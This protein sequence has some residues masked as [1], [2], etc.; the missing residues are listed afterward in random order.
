MGPERGTEV[1]DR[2]PRG[3]LEADLGPAD[4]ILRHGEES[5]RASASYRDPHRPDRLRIGHAAPSTPNPRACRG[6]PARRESGLAADETVLIA[7]HERI[8]ALAGREVADLEGDAP[9]QDERM[10]ATAIMLRDDEESGP[11]QGGIA[12]ASDELGR[13]PRDVP[14]RQEHEPGNR[15]G[16]ERRRGPARST[17][18]SPPV[19][20][21]G[22]RPRPR[23][24][25][26]HRRS[27]VLRV[28]RRAGRRRPR[29]PRRPGAG[30]SRPDGSTSRPGGS[31]AAWVV[32]C[33]RSGPRRAPRRR[34]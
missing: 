12:Q 7:R 6:R 24:D 14:W 31:S 22:R 19:G 8:D 2:R 30:R 29:G 5:N 26:L 1:G 17:P 23:P 15:I 13:D 10:T 11:T 27:R 18:A 4:A 25:G 33:G 3:E 20:P 9:R 32:P 16:L 21:R 34:S 28:H